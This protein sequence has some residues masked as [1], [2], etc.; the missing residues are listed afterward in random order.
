MSRKTLSIC[1]V[2]GAR[3]NGFK[4][5]DKMHQFVIELF[6]SCS[7]FSHLQSRYWPNCV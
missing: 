7:G 3:L 6:T 5:S 1:H 2:V 4:K